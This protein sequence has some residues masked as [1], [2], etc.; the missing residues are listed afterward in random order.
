M[1]LFLSQQRIKRVLYLLIFLIILT[2]SKSS[3]QQETFVSIETIKEAYTQFHF[4]EVIT[5]ADQA[6][7][8]DPP[9]SEEERVQIYTYLAYTYVALGENDKAKESFKEALTLNPTLTLDPIYASPKII[10]VFSEVKSALEAGTDE[11][12]EDRVQ[13]LPPIFKKD[14]RFGGAWRS[15]VLPGW[16]QLYKGHKKKAIVIFAVETFNVGTTLYAHFKMEQ[17]HDEYRRARD[18]ETIESTFDR[19]N[20]YYKLRN[21]FLLFTAVVLMYSHIDAAMSQPELETKEEKGTYW[22]PSITPTSFNLTCS[23][24]F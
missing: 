17:A 13:Q 18:P 16:G 1:I 14:K 3:C 6:L 12:G 4:T 19:Y 22:I 23:I 8:A 20:S 2:W 15:L 7:A 5:L 21:Y 10:A 9:P 24:R 11:I